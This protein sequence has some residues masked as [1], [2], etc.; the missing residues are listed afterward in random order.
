MCYH[1]NTT[2]GNDGCNDPFDKEINQDLLVN[3]SDVDS[4]A[5]YCRK[6]D[7]TGNFFCKM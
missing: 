1:C 5:V 4:R 7:Q 3:C 6:I 2:G